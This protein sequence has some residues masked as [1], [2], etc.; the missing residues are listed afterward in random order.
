MQAERGRLP[1]LP[2][3]GLSPD[4]LGNYLASLGLLRL[5][6]RKWPSVRM[7]WHDDVLHVIGGPPVLDDL[8]EQILAI[9]TSRAWTPYERGWADAQK[10]STMAKSGHRLALW[11]A[12]ADE[13]ELEMLAA[14]AVP[15]ARVSFN[16]LLGSGGNAGKRDFA[17]GWKQA[18]DAL[19]KSGPDTKMRASKKAK[20]NATISEAAIPSDTAHK[21]AELEALL[22]GKPTAWML[23]KLNAASWFGGG[24]NK[25]Y[26]SGQKPSREGRLS[27]WAMA[28]ACEGLAFLAGAASRRLGARARSVGAFP[29]VTH[30]P[31]PAVAGEAGRNLGEV[32]APLWERPMTTP[33]VCALFARGRAEVRGRGA[34]TPSAFATAIMRRGVDAGI[35]EFR[36]FTLGRTTSANTFEPRFEGAFRLPARG[37]AGPRSTSSA[38]SATVVATALER[39]L[40][41][42]ERL[43]PDR[44]VG[45]RWRVSGL[46][47]PLE[48]A[49]LRL[50]AAPYSSEAAR[51]VLDAAVD[52]LV[53][54]DRNRTFRE[55]RV[56]WQPLPIEWLPSL[57]ADEP[58]ELE[59][60]LALA[61]VSA[62]P[63]S[64]PF[65]MYRFGVEWSN[66]CFEH[67]D[68]APARWIWGPGDLPR[69]LS[70]V[71][72]RR[73]LD[74][75]ST[76]KGQR[77]DEDPVRVLMPATCRHISR[78][79]DG[80]ADEQLL[81]RWISRLSLF[82]WRRVPHD[83]R[84]L[85][86]SSAAPSGVNGALC[87]L[88]LFQ[89][90]F[91]RHPVLVRGAAQEDRLDPKRG[92]R[93]P[94]AARTLLGLLRAGDLDAAVRLAS[95]RYATA[96]TF[97]A[98]TDAPWG[99]GEP[100]RFLA[101]I[102]FTIP[103]CER[104]ALN[105]RWLRPRRRRGDETHA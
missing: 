8:L 40:G 34:L 87:L 61:L 95:S 75:E 66:G 2:I 56:S 4:S 92:A 11:Q 26:N 97:L 29:F 17:L 9:A 70:V 59:A 28:F 85:A 68:R 54:V 1:V 62:F 48:A 31:A 13:Q 79:L 33:E 78:W 27:P 60:R 100:E 89:P 21:R 82:D 44:K 90:L 86:Q 42:I 39:V 3:P 99:V 69:V 18:V 25:L 104:A 65:T 91:D 35:T 101:S 58:P 52:S 88:G 23:E 72:A 24:A 53:R 103:D 93:T 51:A 73:T 7:A 15:A 76:R 14:H 74:W 80:A 19:A 98:R 12:G 20:K 57:F 50:A 105:E 49:A 94:A 83:V 63:S 5:L 6:V 84:V 96:G 41:L 77:R 47:G 30:A 102:L 67:P 43:P 55:A 38:T 64:L 16:P 32:W 71:L 46:R 10:Q 81:A 22:L 45:Q 37:N 36:R